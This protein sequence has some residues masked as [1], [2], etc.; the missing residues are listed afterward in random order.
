MKVFISFVKYDKN[1]QPNGFDN[2]IIDLLYLPAN[3]D[4]LKSIEQDLADNYYVN[5]IKIDSMTV[6]N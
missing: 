6:L 3:K 2:D 5:M 1:G 4:S